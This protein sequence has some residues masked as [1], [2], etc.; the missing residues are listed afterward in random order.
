MFASFVSFMFTNLLELVLLDHRLV[1]VLVTFILLTKVS[2]I[3]YYYIIIVSGDLKNKC[4]IENMFD[5]SP[6]KVHSK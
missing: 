3:S 2:I 4:L 1:K 5:F 6:L